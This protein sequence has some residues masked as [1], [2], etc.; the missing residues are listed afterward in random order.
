MLDPLKC[1]VHLSVYVCIICIHMYI[2]MDLPFLCVFVHK[3]YMCIFVYACVCLYF[4]LY[5]CIHLYL[6]GLVIEYQ[7]CLNTNQS[8]HQL[9]SM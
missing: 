9:V 7:F 1:S 5:I 6:G 8:P 2:T 3:Y 4:C